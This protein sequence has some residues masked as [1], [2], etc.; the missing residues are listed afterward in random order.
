MLIWLCSRTCHVTLEELPLLGAY[1]LLSQSDLLPPYTSTHSMP[2]AVSDGLSGAVNSSTLTPS[3]SWNFAR[4]VRA[5]ST[6]LGPHRWFSRPGTT[7]A[8]VSKKL[9]MSLLPPVSYR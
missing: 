7:E 4:T 9:A 1:R 8:G 2:S 3:I 6:S 5:A